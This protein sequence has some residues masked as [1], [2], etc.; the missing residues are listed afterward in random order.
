MTGDNIKTFLNQL[1]YDRDYAQDKIFRNEWYDFVNDM[2]WKKPYH[3]TYSPQKLNKSTEFVE[4]LDGNGYIVTPLY[5]FNESI[6][7][8]IK[9]EYL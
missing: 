7:V 3:F 2:F 9:P 1:K 6:T 8:D 5:Y 4:F